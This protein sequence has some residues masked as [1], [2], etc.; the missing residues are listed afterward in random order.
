MLT[1][2]KPNYPKSATKKESGKL[3]LPGLI[4]GI[5]YGVLVMYATQFNPSIVLVYELVLFFGPDARAG[6]CARAARA[7]L[8]AA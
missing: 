1:Y 3:L 7:R 2:Q 4:A 8:G 6:R 5:M